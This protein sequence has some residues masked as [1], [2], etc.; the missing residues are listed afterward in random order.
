M[1]YHP[2]MLRNDSGYIQFWLDS[3]LKLDIWSSC[4]A[5]V[6]TVWY[7][8]LLCSVQCEIQLDAGW[9]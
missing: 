7:E 9:G 8:M 4:R 1:I 2:S 5:L 6:L 3:I